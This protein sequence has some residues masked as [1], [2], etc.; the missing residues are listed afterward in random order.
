MKHFV[1]GIIC[2][3]P[4]ANANAAKTIVYVIILWL[5]WIFVTRAVMFFLPAANS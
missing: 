3:M 5:S 4:C 1:C 2:L